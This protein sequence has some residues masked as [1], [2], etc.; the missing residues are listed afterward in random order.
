MVCLVLRSQKTINSPRFCWINPT[1]PRTHLWTK[2]RRLSPGFCIKPNRFAT[3]SV[4]YWLVNFVA[5]GAS[6]GNVP[7]FTFCQ[8]SAII[9]A[10]F[11]CGN[12][13]VDDSSWAHYASAV[14]GFVL[15]F[16]ALPCLMHDRYWI[17]ERVL[18][19]ALTYSNHPVVAVAPL[20]IVY[21]AQRPSRFWLSPCLIPLFPWSYR[22]QRHVRNTPEMIE[23]RPNFTRA[24]LSVE[25]CN[26]VFLMRFHIFSGAYAC[27]YF[28]IN[29]LWWQSLVAA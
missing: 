12:F 10:Y 29:C 20:I 28:G 16:I 1:N 2:Q 4:F 18:Y 6:L 24:A 13:H 14:N 25:T 22:P 8:P 21:L 23:L 3:R 5:T 19:P 27:D 9:S 17:N 11:R 15:S 7:K 26:F